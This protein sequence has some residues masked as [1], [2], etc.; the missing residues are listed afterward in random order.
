MS[1]IR[2]FRA[3]RRP[4]GVGPPVGHR[5]GRAA[6]GHRHAAARRAARPHGVRRVG[7][8]ALRLP[9]GRPHRGRVR[10]RR[11]SLRRR[12]GPRAR[13][14]AGPAGR[15]PGQAHGDRRGAGA[16]RVAAPRRSDLPP[17]SRRADG[18]TAA[19]RLRRARWPRAAGLAGAP[20][21]RDRRPRR[22]ADRLR[23]LHRRRSPPG[24][25]FARGLAAARR[26]RRLERPVRRAPDGRVAAVGVP[27]A[28]ARPGRPRRAGR[29]ARAGLHGRAARLGTGPRDRLVRA[30]RR[31]P[32]V[33][34]HAAYRW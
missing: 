29:R 12:A 6:R 7:G 11:A 1:R 26:A 14:G 8:R 3:L 16:G 25:G 9:A 17:G 24:R 28:G 21:R 22:G 18:V 30:L 5:P 32:L 27:P 19:A 13:G 4:P 2:P 23:P 15:Q 34:R 20:G 31:A 33:R 10:G